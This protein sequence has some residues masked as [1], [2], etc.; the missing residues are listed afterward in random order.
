[1]TIEH[2][3]IGQPDADG[4]VAVTDG[5]QPRHVPTAAAS[6]FRTL[7]VGQRVQAQTDAAGA[8]VRVSLP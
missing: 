5:G 1:M 3:T 7:R 2:L 8:V 6:E 4:W